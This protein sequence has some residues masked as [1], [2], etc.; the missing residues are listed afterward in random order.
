MKLCEK[1]LTTSCHEVGPVYNAYSAVQNQKVVSAYL[2][3]KQILAFDVYVKR[4]CAQ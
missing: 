1:A 3:C 2:K 4:V